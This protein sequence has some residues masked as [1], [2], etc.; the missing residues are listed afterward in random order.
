[1]TAAPQPRHRWQKPVRLLA[2]AAVVGSTF[3][4]G[5]VASFAGP[6]RVVMCGGGIDQPGDRWSRVSSP[7]GAT[8]GSVQQLDRS[9]CVLVGADTNGGVWR[10]SDGGRKW[11]RGAAGTALNRVFAERL[12]RAGAGAVGQEVLAT[13][14]ASPAGGAKVYYS[15]DGGSTFA[16][17]KV[18]GATAIA[19]LRSV[20]AGSTS[21]AATYALAEL[22]SGVAGIGAAALPVAGTTP[23]TVL[24]RSDDEGRSFSAVPA[25][26][27]LFAS[28]LAVSPADP[29]QIW[30]NDTRPGGSAAGVVGGAW[31]SD[32]GGQSFAQ[33]CCADRLVN[34]IALA[35]SPNGAVSALLATDSGVVRTDGYGVVT[36][37]LGDATA[38]LGVR[39]LSGGAGVLAE[40]PTSVEAIDGSAVKVTEGLP[41]GCAPRGLRVDNLAPSSFL[42][43]CSHTGGTY[44]LVWDGS[45]LAG[46]SHRSNPQAP[47]SASGALVTA[48]LPLVPLDTVVLPNA[49]STGAAIA[50]DGTTLYY[51]TTKDGYVGRI[52]ARTHAD[53]G[54]LD[55][56]VG[57]WG[58]SMDLRRNR[59]LI[60]TSWSNEG[61]LVAYDLA[62]HTSRSLGNE[63]DKAASYDA[64]D[65]GLT[66]V[67]EDGSTLYKATLTGGPTHV[68]GVCSLL[69]APD[70]SFSV[71]T[72]DG[73]VY[74]QDED[75][76]TVYRFGPP[77]TCPLLGV[78]V[79]RTNSEG[80]ENDTGACDSQTFFP[81]SAIWI[82]D[83][84]IG[85]ATAYAV[86]S[87]YCPMPS[88][89]T[90]SA[91][92]RASAGTTSQVCAHLTNR[93][94][95][96]AAADR[97]VSLFTAG[98]PFG[99]AVT[100]PTGTACWSFPMPGRR[101]VPLLAT[102]AGDAGLYPAR[103]A[104]AIALAVPLA[105]PPHPPTRALFAPPPAAPPA[106]PGGTGPQLTSPQEPVPVPG[107][108]QVAQ[109]QAQSQAQPV[110]HAVVVA[111]RQTQPQL[112][113]AL[114]QSQLNQAEQHLMVGV[115]RPSTPIGQLS[116]AA[117]VGLVAFGCV[118]GALGR[119]VETA[120]N[121]RT[122]SPPLTR[123]RG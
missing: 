93:T 8:L 19:D 83:A 87:G 36:A 16:P 65:D 62:T 39:P 120:R 86:P 66:F 4:L 94:T 110:S 5:A 11:V 42:V 49:G 121:R 106:A 97:V 78:Y 30:V 57:D 100:D 38:Y 28:V 33:A 24:L 61:S 117:G 51:D 18:A 71:A 54:V 96:R 101:S 2:A 113:L 12:A 91:P 105:A 116:L 40:T 32:D 44:R 6:Q 74:V 35:Q 15:A 26:S 55:V 23:D 118:A 88:A 20:A 56:G 89:L 81:Q 34:D 67:R 21:G 75:D 3:G 77:P 17:S 64:S 58:L 37:T 119:A 103:A 102:F 22:S 99:Q 60:T 111:Q 72:G 63:P 50:F 59:L 95:R 70:T 25:T 92:A 123:S 13:G 52:N 1:M 115:R 73:G 79:H 112:S 109:G 9:P 46:P 27:A 7:P 85:S 104:G 29:R 76:R 10:S 69:P 107:Q 53:E 68:Q 43:D 41:D 108:I 90:L 98:R 80:K 48:P 31:L 14:A 114:A 45:S 122:G 47:P 82:R 84:T